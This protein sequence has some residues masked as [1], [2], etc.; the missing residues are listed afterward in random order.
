MSNENLLVGFDTNDDGAVYKL[1]DD[2]AIIQTLDFFPPLCDDPYT[3]GQIAAANALSDVAAMGGVPTLA[4]NILAF[5]NDGDPAYLEAMLA[6]GAQKVQEAGAVLAGGHSIADDT[7]K[8]GLSVMGVVH[9]NDI[10]YN[11][12]CEMGDVVVLTKPLGVGIVAAQ[13]AAGNASKATF[14][15]AVKHMTY[16]NTITMDIARKYKISAATDVT[17]F[18]FLGHLNEM[19]C[20]NSIVVDAASIPLVNGALELTTSGKVTGGGK[21][22]RTSLGE[23][24]DYGNVDVALQELM[25]DPQTSGGLLLSMSKNDAKQLVKDLAQKGIIAAV[26]A[27]V[28]PK[29]E[30]N[31]IL[32]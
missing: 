8:Y 1:R 19:V 18:G 10:L 20:G 6:G 7:V 3:F 22:N 28:I 30:K 26:V 12:R 15:E 2:L 29:S 32:T 14:D 21:K 17:G 27:E 16:L 9:P 31:I 24:I 11:N 4:L 13:Y 5:P 23:K 25:L